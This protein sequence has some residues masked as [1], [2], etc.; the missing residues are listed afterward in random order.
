MA[1]INLKQRILLGPGPSNVHPRVLQALSLPLVGHL[2]P[3]FVELMNQIQEMLRYVFQT[4]NSLT[5]PVSG[6]GSAG[7]EA[8]L[9][10]FIEPGDAVLVCVM[11][12]FGE[13]LVEM[14][15]RYGAQITRIDRPWGEAFTLEDVAAALQ[16]KPAHLVAMIHAE[17]STGVMQPMQGM[18]ELVHAQGGLLVM[19]C[20]ASLGGVPVKVDE[21]GV[22]IAFSGSQKCL[23]VPPGLAPITVSPRAQ[24]YLS[25]RNS[26][27]ANWYLDL[28]MVSKFWGKERTYHHTAPISLNYALY[29]GLKLVTEEGL[30]ARWER[31]RL[32]AELLCEGLEKLG[33]EL[34]VPVP[35]RLA[36]IT[37]MKIPEGADDLA[38]RSAL[39]NDYGIEIAG[40][41]G[42]N[43]GKVWRI[44]LM[45]HSSQ[46]ENV[47]LVLA[48][49]KELL[50]K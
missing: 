31:H 29:E 36:S 40:G 42:G 37:T 20:V 38:V 24:A 50:R 27:I 2:D 46:R 22:D 49:L 34:I 13:R 14:A 33:L 30:E 21:W 7:M 10:N 41:I 26:K 32:N 15:S 12:Y 47:N 45:G 43:K 11:G 18:A 8:A 6:T 4:Q 1:S 35:H 5:I 23:S 48:A 39:L 19:D 3:Q 17:T 44:G 16:K 9:C 28:T 25:A